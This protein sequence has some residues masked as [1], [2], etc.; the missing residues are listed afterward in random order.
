M[1]TWSHLEGKLDEVP[2][3]PEKADV[4]FAA[5]RELPTEL[6]A[7]IAKLNEHLDKRDDLKSSEKQNNFALETV[8]YALA[9]AMKAQGLESVVAGGYRF[10]PVPEPYASVTDK[11]E[12]IDW[13][14][15][16]GAAET[17]Q[18]PWQTLQAL[19]K[20]AL[21][22]GTELPPGVDV[23]LKRDVRRTKSK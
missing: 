23:Y 21:D 18:F 9:K 20:I 14:I 11:K 4:F 2:Q 16:D 3:D 7:L 1:A 6:P 5:V 12:L 13:A 22:A 15:K 17:L 19:V 8:K 10:T